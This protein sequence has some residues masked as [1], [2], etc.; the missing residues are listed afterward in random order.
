MMPLTPAGKRQG[1]K[2]DHVLALR[3]KRADP[4]DKKTVR[5]LCRSR[6]KMKRAR[7]LP[8]S[9]RYKPLSAETQHFSTLQIPQPLTVRLKS[10][11]AP[12]ARAR[13]LAAQSVQHGPSVG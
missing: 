7:L 3:I 11:Q 12:C 4:A 2:R 10:V 5:E 6:T 8:N 9:G 1:L 13:A